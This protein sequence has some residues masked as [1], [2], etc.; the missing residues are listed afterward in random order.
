MRGSHGR[1]IFVEEVG[2]GLVRGTRLY[3]VIQQGRRGGADAPGRT[4]RRDG[5]RGR[6]RC[7][8][9]H[10]AAGGGG[11]RRLGRD[12]ATNPRGRACFIRSFRLSAGNNARSDRRRGRRRESGAHHGAHRRFQTRARVLH[13][14]RAVVAVDRR[15]CDGPQKLVA[16]NKQEP[17][18]GA[19]FVMTTPRGSSARLKSGRALVAAGRGHGFRAG[20]R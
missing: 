13:L 2:A 8:E 20:G 7:A 11:R 6:R 19:S 17:D 9:P 10:A 12:S 4:R 14:P 3:G 1:E 5:R 15:R 18:D 16:G